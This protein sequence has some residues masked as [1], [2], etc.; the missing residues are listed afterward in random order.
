M[1]EWLT[2]LDN[3]GFIWKWQ[4]KWY[5]DIITNKPKSDV[6]QMQQATV[7][8]LWSRLR[9]N[10]QVALEQQIRCTQQ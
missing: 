1:Q 7:V 2:E 9:V 4:L 5:M 8:I 6:W 3:S 10:I